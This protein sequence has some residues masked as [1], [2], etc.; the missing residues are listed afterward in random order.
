MAAEM[1]RASWARWHPAGSGIDVYGCHPDRKPRP[2]PVGL[3]RRDLPVVGTRS[4][5]RC[6]PVS[7][8]STR[9]TPLAR[10]D[11]F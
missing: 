9:A 3:K 6:K 11:S 8:P 2:S 10:D 5:R 1:G 7:G 4:K